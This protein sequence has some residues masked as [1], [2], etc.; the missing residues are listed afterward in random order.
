MLATIGVVALHAVVARGPLDIRPSA[1]GMPAGATIVEAR[2]LPRPARQDRALVLWMRSP[3]RHPRGMDD[4][5]AYACPEYSRGDHFSGPTRVSLLDLA[6]RRVVNTRVVRDPRSGEDTFD[7]PYRFW[8]GAETYAVDGP[9]EHEM[10]RPRILALRDV[11][12]DGK[13]FEFVLYASEDCM[14]LETTLLGY[15]E[16]RDA[17]IQYTAR[18]GPP[19]RPKRWR[20]AWVDGLF[21]AAPVRRGH[22]VYD[23]DYSGRGGCRERYDIRYDPKREAF[24]GTVAETECDQ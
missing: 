19:G 7:V 4:D 12:G 6:K 10:G 1:F 8:A 15:S 23:V 21:A 22:W 5:A 16:R 24:E 18:L 3:S 11:N 14:E 20:Q 2:R 17:V 13:P 9:T